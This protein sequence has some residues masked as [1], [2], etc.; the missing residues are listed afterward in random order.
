MQLWDWRARL[1]KNYERKK[2]TT[3]KVKLIRSRLSTSWLLCR[4]SGTLTSTCDACSI[5]STL[6]EATAIAFKIVVI[7]I[8]VTWRHVAPTVEDIIRVRHGTTHTGTQDTCSDTEFLL[9][10]I[11]TTFI[12]LIKIS[13]VTRKRKVGFR[14][15]LC[16][17]WIRFGQHIVILT[18]I[19]SS[20][21]STHEW[22]SYVVN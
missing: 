15:L 6:F 2:L 5:I 11:E 14:P 21:C 16:L 9:S 4:N 13:I 18:P 10:T 12:Q 3:H 8:L 22:F 17:I 7:N 1:Y 20:F 19:R